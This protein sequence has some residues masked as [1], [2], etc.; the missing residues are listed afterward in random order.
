[1][2]EEGLWEKLVECGAGGRK[3]RFPDRREGL[4]SFPKM[5]IRMGER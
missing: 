3:D 5:E 2:W 4:S 1:M